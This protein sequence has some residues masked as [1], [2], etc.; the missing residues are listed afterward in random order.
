MVLICNPAGVVDAKHPGQGLGDI[1]LAG[2]DQ[3]LLSTEFC[4]DEQKFKTMSRE[5][6]IT[7]AE[8]L[9]YVPDH[10]EKLPEAMKPFLEMLRQKKM[11]CDYALASHLPRDRKNF[12]LNKMIVPIVEGAVRL[13]VQNGCKGYI[14]LCPIRYFGIVGIGL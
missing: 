3:V 6:R 12:E 13:A 5:R 11:R 4:C 1:E 2:F 9:I 8:H 14:I 10:P 7:E